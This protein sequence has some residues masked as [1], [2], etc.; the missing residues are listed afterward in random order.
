MGFRDITRPCHWVFSSMSTGSNLFDL[1]ILALDILFFCIPGLGSLHMY[2]DILLL[3]SVDTTVFCMNQKDWLPHLE[4]WD[5]EERESTQNALLWPTLHKTGLAGAMQQLGQLYVGV[6]NQGAAAF[7][8]CIRHKV[9]SSSNDL[10]TG[11]NWSQVPTALN[12]EQRQW[13]WSSPTSA[14]TL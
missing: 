2:T 3:L 13:P 11:G 14:R 5:W 8:L 6:G 4:E 10:D 12:R 7:H 9:L 1:T